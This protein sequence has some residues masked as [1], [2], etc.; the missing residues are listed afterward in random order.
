MSFTS[1]N[2]LYL[3]FQAV[4]PDSLPCFPVELTCRNWMDYT[5]KEAI[6]KQ[7]N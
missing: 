6:W 7:P 3:I 4:N 5:W 2:I 1:Q